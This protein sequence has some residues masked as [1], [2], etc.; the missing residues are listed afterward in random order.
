MKSKP[1][2]IL[3]DFGGCLDS[4][5]MHSRKLFLDQ[6]ARF[7]LINPKEHYSLFQ[8]AYTYSDRKVIDEALVANSTLL[9]M[10]VIMCDLIAE[11]I[12]QKNNLEIHK[13]AEAITAAQSYYLKR[14]K[15]ILGSLKK[16]FKLGIISNFSGNL[17]VILNEFSLI[18]NF[19]FVLDSYHAGFEKPDPEI[20]KLAL[21]RCQTNPK[22]VCFVGDNPDRDIKPAKTLGIKTI[23]IDPNLKSSIA[24]YTLDSIEDILSLSFNS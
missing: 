3:F 11:K 19:N 22:E 16:G 14:N 6:F 7:G 5:G 23:L 21:N 8:D 2:W 13:V 15:Q 9:N 18:D 24:D 1:K 10:N 12:N 4:D 20:F 17:E